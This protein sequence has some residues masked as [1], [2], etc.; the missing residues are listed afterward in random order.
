MSMTKT[1]A[2]KKMKEKGAYDALDL[3]TKASSGE[4]TDTEIID[5]EEAIPNFDREKDYTNS[6]IGTPIQ[7]DGQVFGL[8][9]PHNAAS[10]EGTPMTL[11]NLWALKHTKNPAKA[12]PYV[13]PLG[14]SGLYM[15]DECCVVDDIVYVSEVNNNNYSPTE[16]AQNW[17]VYNAE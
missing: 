8:L 9:Q 1:E 11:R 3:R 15:K 2:L 6:P 4:L 14:T 17:A 16:Y 5:K 12:K 10:Y 13:A 7:D